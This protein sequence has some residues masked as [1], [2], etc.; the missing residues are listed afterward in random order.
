[1]HS[2]SVGNNPCIPTFTWTPDS[3]NPGNGVV[4][5]NVISPCGG[6]VV[7]NFGDS[8][9]ATGNN[10]THQYGTPGWF[11]VCITVIIQNITYTYCDSVYSN[12]VLSIN[13]IDDAFNSQLYPNPAHDFIDISLN[14]NNTDAIRFEIVDITG[15]IIQKTESS[16][17]PL[18]NS[19]TRIN[20]NGLDRG[21]Y[22]VRISSSENSTTIRFLI[23]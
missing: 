18:G 15:R 6:T 2:V 11:T 12:R 20:L 17:L 3:L 7:W 23:Q 10:P 14:I 4:F 13:H 22:F 8:T 19:E 21:M 9:V 16:Q 1:M 5:F